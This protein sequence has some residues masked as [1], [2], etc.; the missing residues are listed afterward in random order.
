M[1]DSAG[2]GTGGGTSPVYSAPQTRVMLPAAVVE[3]YWLAHARGYL[4]TI[5]IAGPRTAPVIERWLARLGAPWRDDETPWCGIFVAGVLDEAGAGA[6]P[7]PSH[8][9]RARAWLEWGTPIPLPL[10][11]CVAV[12][13][14]GPAAGHVGFVVGRTYAG[15]LLILGGNQGNRVSVAAFPRWRA[16][17]YRWPPAEPLPGYHAALPTGDAAQS[18]T[19]A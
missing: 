16:I 15:D 19:E 18:T 10:L 11:G 7:L 12:F 2:N 6:L 1:I 17:G 14:R 8:Y 13:E 3:P 4:G 9:Y 5:E